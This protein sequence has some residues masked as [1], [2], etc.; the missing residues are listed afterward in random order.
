MQYNLIE[1]DYGVE[2]NMMGEFTFRD[3]DACFEAINYVK[4]NHPKIVV[5]NMKDCDF[6][7]SA[8]LGMLVILYD[9]IV[10]YNGK[11]IIINLN[12]KNKSI[13]NNARFENI[14]DVELKK[15]FLSEKSVDEY[16]TR[17]YNLSDIIIKEKPKP[18][19]IR[20][21]PELLMDEEGCVTVNGKKYKVVKQKELDFDLG[22]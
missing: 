22:I 11:K 18:K 1:K 2:I 5:L 12:R 15:E 16:I 19:K 14:Y 13:I 20:E 3:H 4:K 21:L 17:K 7:D 10:D 6:I 9:E 8:A